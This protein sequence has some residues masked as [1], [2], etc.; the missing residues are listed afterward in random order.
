M[1][2][3]T[4]KNAFFFESYLLPGESFYL[5]SRLGDKRNAEATEFVPGFSGSFCSLIF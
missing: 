5:F 2:I 4:R 3:L 1:E